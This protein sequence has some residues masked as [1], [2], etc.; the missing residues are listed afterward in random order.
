MTE[1]RDEWAVRV[2]DKLF[3]DTRAVLDRLPEP[4]VGHGWSVTHPHRDEPRTVRIELTNH[5]GL[6]T[7]L[8]GQNYAPDLYGLSGVTEVGVRLLKGWAR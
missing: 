7:V 6:P 8:G 5:V 1:K 3:A 4:P 2:D